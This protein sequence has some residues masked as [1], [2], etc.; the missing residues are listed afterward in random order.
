MSFWA[1]WCVPCRRE[2]PHLEKL[3]QEFGDQG[4]TIIGVN[5]DPPGTTSKIKPYIKRYQISYTTLLDP[6]N[7]V[8]DK[9]NPTRELPYAVLIDRTGNVVQV[10][11]GYRTGDEEVLREKIVDCSDRAATP[12][13]PVRPSRRGLVVAAI[14]VLAGSASAQ[15]NDPAPAKTY[16][17]FGQLTTLF[18]RNLTGPE[19][20]QPDR[21]QY[22]K[23]KQLASFNIEWKKISI[24]VQAEYLEWSV[25]EENRDRFD[26]DRLREGLELRRYFI[27]YQIGSVLRP[28]RH[29]LRLFRPRPDTLCSEE[30]GPPVRR[31]HPRRL[32]QTQPQTLRHLGSLGQG[33]RAGPTGA[34]RTRVRGRGHGRPDP[35]QASVGSLPRRL[36]GAGRAR[37]A[38]SSH[39][40]RSPGH[41]RHRRGLVRRGRRQRDRRRFSISP[42]RSPRSTRPKASR[43]KEGYGRYFSAAA[44]IG[45]V[46]ILGEY[47]DYYNFAYRY[48]LPP[49]AG[50]ADEA[51]EHNDVKGP[52]LLVSADLFST[53]TLLHASYASFNTHKEPT[54]PGGTAGDGQNE[55]Y[56]GIEQTIGRVY[57]TGSYFD[58]DWVDREID[59]K[60][61]LADL[62]VTG[63]TI[64]ARSSSGWTNASK[65]PSTSAWTPPA[66]FSPTPSPPGAPFPCAT[67]GKSAADSTGKISGA[68]RSSTSRN[69]ASSSPFSAA[70]TRA[71]S[72]APAA[73]A[74]QEPRFEG[75]KANFTWRF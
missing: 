29:H 13:G 40:R 70:A 27:D 69:R 23:F 41:Q 14:L 17:I 52:R 54:S 19:P 37:T 66:A 26:F 21:L 55:W 58:R 32:R 2:M 9:Y 74:A 34:I 11:P 67:P 36:R 71:G 50:R 28:A 42:P 48:N 16:R 30:R 33:L 5:T 3:H 62:H 72:S 1:T 20:T 53:G 51:Y 75:F 12:A 46:S 60:H 25:L 61:T 38:L 7:N 45:P 65:S 68:S 22:T 24:G 39:G 8:L 43:V 35:R 47:K 63:R 31:A 10:F 49:N 18:E 4:L 73:S 44:Y 59:E 64:A 6:D 15:D 57:F 56:A